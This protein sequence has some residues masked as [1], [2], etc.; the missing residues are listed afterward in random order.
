MNTHRAL[1]YH[2][3]AILPLHSIAGTRSQLEDVNSTVLSVRD[4][5]HHLL[6]R[7][8]AT[9]MNQK[10]KRVKRQAAVMALADP[11]LDL[12]WS[13]GNTLRRRRLHRLRL[14][15]RLRLRLRHPHLHRRRSAV[16]T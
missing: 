12:P 5:A 11:V 7:K 9:P 10:R 8:M 1:C 13:Q 14:H 2:L 3:C 6:L 16:W 4:L 15:H